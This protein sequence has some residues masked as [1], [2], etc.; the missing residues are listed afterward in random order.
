LEP[1]HQGP[2]TE[3]L[4]FERLARLWRGPAV[5]VAPDAPMSPSPP[6]APTFE[7]ETESRGLSAADWC[8][9]RRERSMLYASIT[10]ESVAAL[11]ERHPDR[12]DRTLA[13][14]ERILRHEFDLLG[15]GAYVPA[16]PDRT[17]HD[18][19]A[20]IDWYV[21]PVRKLRF[22]RS[23]HHKSWN[24]LEMRPANADIKY[25]WELARCQHWATLGQAFLFTN[26]D[27]FALEIAR[28][29]DD[30]MEA[31]PV[32]IGVNWTC[33]MDVA[34]R[35]VSWAIGLELVR[36]SVALDDAF[37]A[38]AYTAL[39]DHGVFIRNNLENTYEVTSNHFLSNL[40]GL[41][42][43]SAVFADLA[44]GEEWHTFSRAAVE[45][46]M[47]VQVLADG[48]DYESSIP[49]HRLV[50][51]LFLGAAR[52]A[53]HRG[54]P[55]SAAYRSRLHAMGAYLA[56]VTRP[57]G[58]MPQVGDADD[59]RLHILEGYGTATPQ[60]AR[61]LLGP[62][63]A[64]FEEPGWCA[65]A[66]DAGAWEAAWWGFPV[67]ATSAP[68]RRVEPFAHLFPQAGIAVMRSLPAHY[69]IVTNGI[70]GTNGFG[71]HKHN[72]LL[73]FEYHHG[74]TS[75]VVDPGSYVYTS[76]ADA[77]NRFRGTAYHNTLM[78]DGVEQNELRP[79]WLFRLFETSKAESLSFDD[80]TDAAI[81]VGRHHGYERLPEPVTHE[82]TF[83]FE[84]ASGSLW[85]TDRLIGR[86]VH[87]LRWHFHLAPGILAER[88]P[89]S[90]VLLAAS[91]G[92]W[93][94]MAPPD[95][96]IGIEAAAYSPSYGVRVPCVALDL[97]RRV[98]L[99]G[100]RSWEFSIVPW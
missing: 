91:A 76:D 45:Q 55:L 36:T 15:S 14:A 58:L 27:R 10:P 16:D 74:G 6:L 37:W 85:I 70:V 17:M 29:L 43:L 49:Y 66:G 54:E 98:D 2:E 67:A 75:L 92:R 30:F 53:E 22:P 99:A 73:S 38:R 63:A 88:A 24:L 19:Y 34:L 9:R 8:R 97:S 87:D 35:A 71:N 48:A 90:T 82:R 11:R 18:G 94:L 77:R 79:D 95:I 39:Y 46:E 44:Q 3:P 84:K 80:R 40:V 1:H 41:I 4:M 56:A 32:G 21:D 78:I 20:S 61:H 31:N 42:F 23:V 86:G 96:S 62:A 25:P 100:E 28:E 68:D 5:D 93:R 59:G 64:M 47:T 81:Y 26:D 89:D 72:D 12:V 69:V 7:Q 52:Q 50:T 33:T 83:R 65:L 57:D 51:E 60:D 13:A